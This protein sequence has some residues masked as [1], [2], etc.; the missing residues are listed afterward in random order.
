MAPREEA[1]HTALGTLIK[2]GAIDPADLVALKLG[3]EDKDLAIKLSC[4]QPTQE[5]LNGRK[6]NFGGKKRCCTQWAFFHNQDSRRN[7]VSYS[8]SK[9]ALFCIPCLLFS[10][11]N[12]R[13][14]NRRLVQGSS[15]TSNGFSNW[16]KQYEAIQKHGMSES[17]INSTVAQGLFLQNRSIHNLLEKELALEKQRTR[18]E[19]V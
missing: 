14:E 11:A 10:D 15:F 17:H 16:K 1:R 4:C 7:W 5:V 19:V 18:E 3:V 6:T 9:N 13:G 12:F 8:M 2:E